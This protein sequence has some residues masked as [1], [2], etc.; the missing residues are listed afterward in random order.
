MLTDN[1]QDVD[2]RISAAPPAAGYLCMCLRTELVCAKV[3]TGLHGQA[4]AAASG[5]HAYPSRSSTATPRTHATH[6]TH[7]P[8][9]AAAQ[10]DIAGG[11]LGHLHQEG[12]ALLGRTPLALP[13]DRVGEGEAGVSD[14]AAACD[15][16]QRDALALPAASAAEVRVGG[17]GGV[18]GT[19]RLHGHE[20]L[21]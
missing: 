21:G 6:A 9:E 18:H 19:Q 5:T 14:V 2:I 3:R 11:A 4:L 12:A 16:K 20:G 17:G 10:G 7:T 15:C 1:V 13:A 8:L